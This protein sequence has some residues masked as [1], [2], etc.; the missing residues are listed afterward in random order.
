MLVFFLKSLGFVLAH[1][2]QDVCRFFCL[3]IGHL[4][5]WILGRRYHTHSNLHHAFPEKSGKWR[6]R[7][8]R[9]SVHRLVE[10]SL[11][12]LVIPYWSDKDIRRRFIMPERTHKNMQAW[13]DIPVITLIPHLS[14]SECLTMIQW[15]E[16]SLPPSASLFRPLKPAAVDAY[17]Q[18]SRE[19]FNIKMFSRREGLIKSRRHLAKGGWLGLLFDQNTGESGALV[20][21]FGRICSASDIGG[22]LAKKENAQ[23]A[24]MWPERTGFWQANIH[25][26]PL[27]AP[28]NAVDTT[29]ASHQWL[30]NHL[31]QSDENCQNWMR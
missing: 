6:G 9:E 31:E 7:I 12:P 18:A 5:Y 8:G 28:V 29:I 23:I 4:I 22:A 15:L 3:C 11:L 17:V 16:P 13:A 2:P 19:R 10:W 25:F 24:M 21:M 1:I 26:E 20:T 27:E 30:E 14:L